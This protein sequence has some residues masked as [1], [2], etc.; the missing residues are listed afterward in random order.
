MGHRH[1]FKQRN[2]PKEPE[3]EMGSAQPH[4]ATQP[5]E[6]CSAGPVQHSVQEQFQCVLARTYLAA[7]KPIGNLKLF[8]YH[9]R[10]TAELFRLSYRK[11]IGNFTVNLSRCR[12]LVAMGRG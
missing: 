2:A 9:A 10:N 3:A 12:P 8:S 1:Q 11:I 6:L 5:M 4:V 7:G